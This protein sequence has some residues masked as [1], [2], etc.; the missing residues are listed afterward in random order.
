MSSPIIAIVAPGAMG[1]AVARVLADSGCTVL[2]N[3]DDRTAKTVKRAEEA[4]MK[5]A[6]YEEIVDT[7]EWVLSI[8]PPVDAYSVAEKVVSAAKSRT[9]KREF[10]GYVDCNAISPKEV[11]RIAELC[12]SASIPF[13]DAAIIGGPPNKD[14]T[15]KFYA[16]GTDPVILNRFFELS[17]HGLKISLLDGGVGSASAL[18]MSYAVSTVKSGNED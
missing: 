9:Q 7:A 15:P 13:V 2:T 8:L 17:E 4:G 3:V 14:Y 18:K 6:S 11:G 1:A 16:S 5:H 12:S 10:F